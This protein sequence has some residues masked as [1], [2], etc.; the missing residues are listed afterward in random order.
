[1]KRVYEEHAGE[2][3]QVVGLGIQ[4][5]LKNIRTFAEAEGVSWPVAFDADDKVAKAYGITFGAGAVFIDRAG[6]VRKRYFAAFSEEELDE[7]LKLI[8]SSVP[9]ST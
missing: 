5:S 9:E 7:N 8:L 3:L 6:I 1:V 4:D 2:G